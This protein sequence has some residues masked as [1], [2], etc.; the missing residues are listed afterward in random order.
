MDA[1]IIQPIQ[2][3]EHPP[4]SPA[5]LSTLIAQAEFMVERDGPRGI[6]LATA[7]EQCARAL[8][9]DEGVV[10]ALYVRGRSSSLC[11]EF[12]GA[13][14]VYTEALALCEEH[15][16]VRYLPELLE[17]QAIAH[18]N[19]GD[20]A[21]SFRLLTRALAL[22][23]RGSDRTVEVEILGELG[24]L[25]CW[26][27]IFDAALDLHHQALAL[28]RSLASAPA[29]ARRAQALGHTYRWQGQTLHHEGNPATAEAALAA[30]VPL[31]E[32]ALALAQAADDVQLTMFCFGDLSVIAYL[33]GDT[34]RAREL[35]RITDDGIAQLGSPRYRADNLFG[36]GWIEAVEG[37]HHAALTAFEAARDIYERLGGH[38]YLRDLHRSISASYEALGDTAN[39]LAHFHRFYEYDRAATR[40]KARQTVMLTDLNDQLRERAVRDP[41]TGLFN[42]R[43][44][45]DIL[46]RE[47]ANAHIGAL[48]V[49]VVTLDLDHFKAIND[50]YGHAAGDGMLRAIGDLLL[51]ETRLGDAVCRIGGEEFV[52]VLPG[53]EASAA[54]QWAEQRRL[55]FAALHVT[56]AGTELHTTFSAG[57]AT[58][59][60]D[61]DTA[62]A[63]LQA[64]DR[65]LYA[66]KR[67]GRNRVVTLGSTI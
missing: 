9:D 42:R 46:A 34:T 21:E 11:G 43:Y 60:G 8:G 53:A 61:G 58:A 15:G 54:W 25:Y 33:R 55:A 12:A 31:L 59:P 44:L 2:P 17:W 20:W 6:V 22:A 28:A 1:T 49:S 41:L 50:T 51:S 23:R 3:T 66:A 45:E 16:F 14:D 38:P 48:P 64:S 19:M 37:N 18:S 29:I 5:Q 65:A 47:L 32:E 4:A 52:V 10:R 62:D 30:A 63:L 39:A 26:F 56:H 24:I 13:I 35:L 40:E 27:E 57:V 67:T 7:A 36:W